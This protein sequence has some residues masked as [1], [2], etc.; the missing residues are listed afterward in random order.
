MQ[1]RI[2]DLSVLFDDDGKIY[3]IHGYGEVKCTELKPDM[4]GPIEETERTIIPEGNAVGEGHHMYKIN[5]NAL[6]SFEE[7]L[8]PLRD[9]HHYCRRDFRL[10]SGAVDTG[11]SG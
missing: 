5:G 2:Y 1:G 9:H 11:A 3:A 7:H 6:F 8:G 10:S 4:S